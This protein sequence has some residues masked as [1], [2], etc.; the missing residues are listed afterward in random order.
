MLLL[1]SDPDSPP[2]WFIDNHILEEKIREQGVALVA[3]AVWV[4]LDVDT[5]ARGRH[6]YV[7]ESNVT[8][9][10]AEE[11]AIVRDQ[12]RRDRPASGHVTY[13]TYGKP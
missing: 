2:L 6:G 8:H 12:L 4:A 5:F 11:A 9:A 10:G 13:H 3:I 1:G 7:P